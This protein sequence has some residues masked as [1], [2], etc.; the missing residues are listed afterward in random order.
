M[1]YHKACLYA[2][3]VLVYFTKRLSSKNKYLHYRTCYLFHTIVFDEI[4]LYYYNKSQSSVRTNTE[5][6]ISSMVSEVFTNFIAPLYQ[7]LF[8]HYDTSYK[9][10]DRT[11]RKHGCTQPH[12]VS[13]DIN[14]NRI[15]YF[16][17][18]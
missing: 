18:I 4:E 16:E 5:F 13:F 2:K 14:K 10:T 7:S 17:K 6:G 8:M 11:V 1:D 3:E 12:K 9:S 15:H